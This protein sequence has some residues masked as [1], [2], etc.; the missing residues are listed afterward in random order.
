MINLKKPFHPIPVPFFLFSSDWTH[1]SMT[2]C[3]G[4]T[5]IG[6]VGSLL[7]P[8]KNWGS[9]SVCTLDGKHLYFLNHLA[10]PKIGL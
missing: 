2:A 5:M 6:G 10:G 1:V 7:P 9:N 3:G 8:W 4:Q